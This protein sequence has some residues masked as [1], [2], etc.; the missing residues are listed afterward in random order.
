MPVVRRKVLV[1]FIVILLLVLLFC[2]AF[3]KVGAPMEEGALLVYPE[4]ILKGAVPYRDFETFY[5]PA[6]LWLLSGIYAVTGPGIFVERTVGLLYRIAILAALFLLL[7]RY[8]VSLAAGCSI[9]AGLLFV[10]L[11]LGAF[12]WSG[13]LMCLLW[14]ICFSV[15]PG[16][17][18]QTFFGGLL[19]GLALLFRP[20]LAPA[21]LAA[22]LPL[23]LLMHSSAR[24]NYLGGVA[25]GLLPYGLL[26]VIAGPRNMLDNLVLF[27]V[28]Y[29]SPG[30]HI[31]ILS[32]EPYVLRLFFMHL[33]AVAINLFAGG[34]AVT[35]FRTRVSARLLLSLALLGLA[36]THQAAQRLDF[37][38]LICA[39]LL[40]IP[41]LPFSMCILY[42]QWRESPVR[43]GHAV[44]AT[45][46]VMLALLLLAPRLAQEA[47]REL[48]SSLNS[49]ADDTFFIEREGRSFPTPSAQLARSISRLLNQLMETAKPADRVFVGPSDL[50]RTNY[51]DT[52]IYHLLPQLRPATYFLEMNPLSANRANSR[53][54]T[55]LASA[56]WVILSNCWDYWNE[57]N[58]S[59][60]FGSSAPMQVMQ[61]QFRVCGRFGGYDLYRRRAPIVVQN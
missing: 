27:P 1:G 58:E 40:S 15:K 31:P 48:L 45:A 50:R 21:G 55:D 47:Q 38:H 52:F 57:P 14:S 18:K 17:P 5:G 4:L 3:E 36:L 32:A 33:A 35:R 20:D 61:T 53:L 2:P 34:L 19:I 42:A 44:T 26:A 6:N 13:G 23:F 25:L 59:S 10:P 29:S 16:S 46:I 24:K 28:F 11:G 7:A 54:A 37:G 49:E 51:N 8:S 60:K 56:D 39:A 41:I 12:A 22:G 30:R 43:I 9:A